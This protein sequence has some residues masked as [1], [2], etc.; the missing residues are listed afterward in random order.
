MKD[1]VGYTPAECAALGRVFAKLRFPAM[2]PVIG[3]VL[4]RQVDFLQKLAQDLA[5]EP[6]VKDVLA[7]Y[8]QRLLDITSVDGQ[9][10][11]HI[12]EEMRKTLTPQDKE[13]G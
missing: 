12:L 2:G 10:Q 7:G 8:T 9:V 11:G 5:M 13:G 1:I 3:M 4:L 6:A